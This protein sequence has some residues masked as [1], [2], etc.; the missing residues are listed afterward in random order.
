MVVKKYPGSFGVIGVKRSFSPELSPDYMVWSCDFIK[1]QMTLYKSYG[2][3]RS[4]GYLGSQGSKRSFSQ[5]MLFLLQITCYG[6]VTHTYS[7]ARYPLQ[8]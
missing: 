2:R 8:K 1:Q 7:S 4:P 6:H 5:K 3:K